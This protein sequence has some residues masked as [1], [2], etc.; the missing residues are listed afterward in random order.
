MNPEYAIGAVTEEGLA[1]WNET[2]KAAVDPKWL[3]K[4]VAKER[5]EA[6]RR[7]E[8]YS[9]GRPRLPLK[10]KTVLI[11]D[12]GLATGLTMRAAVAEAKS[13]QARQIVI[14]VPVAP[15]ETVETIGQEVDKV[16]V[17]K[18]PAFLGAV[19]Q[20]YESFNQVSDEEVIK[21]INSEQKPAARS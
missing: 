21:M 15:P 7:R 2:E 18:T 8:T 11:V 1:V 10:E 9:T 19:G 14:A 6:K 5:A 3:E 20:Y 13:L 16:I 12:D 17:L 4:E